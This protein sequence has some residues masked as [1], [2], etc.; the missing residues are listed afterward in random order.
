MKRF[1]LAILALALIGGLVFGLYTIIA[2]LVKDEIGG[3]IDDVISDL[4]PSTSAPDIVPDGMVKI[5]IVTFKQSPESGEYERLEQPMYI[6]KN[7]R[8]THEPTAVEHYRLNTETS[9][10]TIDN[11]ASGNEIHI[12]LDCETCKI[13][14]SIG[15]A[16]LVDGYAIQTIRKGQTP[17]APTLSLPGYTLIGYDHELKPTYEDTVF[18]PS[19]EITNYTLR[20]YLPQG[21]IIDKS[22]YTVNEHFDG[23]FETT[24]TFKDALSLPTPS[25]EG[26]TFRSWN[27]KPDGSGNTVTTLTENTFGDTDLYAIT[28]IKQYTLTFSAVDGL[29]FPSYYLPQGASIS[30]PT[31]PPEAQKPG[32]G[33]TWYTDRALTNVYDFYTMPKENLIL[34]GK[35]QEDTGDGFLDWDPETFYQ[36][37]TI[38]SLIE[39]VD[40]ID[41]IRFYNIQEPIRIEVTYTDKNSL[42][43]EVEKAEKLC[44]YRTSGSLSYSAGIGSFT[45]KDAKCYLSMKVGTSFADSEAKISTNSTG[46]KAYTLLQDKI[47]PRGE[48]YT[49]FYIEKLTETYAVTST[50]Q[51]LY[52][53]EHG[54]K[55][56]PQ[57]G[58]P[59]FEIYEKAK[60]IL[61][62][63]LPNDATAIEKAEYIFNYL[64][65]HIEYDQEA[66][67]IAEKNPA[68]WPKYDAFYLEGVFLYNKAVCDGIAKAYSL[69]C[70]IEGIPCVEVVGPG[71]AWNRVKVDNRWYVVDATFGNLHITGN[72]LSI[73]DHTQFLISDADKAA[74]GYP[75]QN[76]LEFSADKNY[77][78]FDKKEI[79]Y[80]RRTFDFVID[81]VE[82]L[83]RFMEYTLSLKDSFKD[84]TINIIYKINGM[85]FSSAFRAAKQILL[86][87][88]IVFSVTVSCYGSGY[89]TSHKLVYNSK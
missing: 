72:S 66:V 11:A 75:V 14:F 85:D 33:L 20:L 18:L 59:A 21:A 70:N 68:D 67:K 16:D 69:L 1:I 61:N 13:T 81:S 58:S 32:Y 34:Y 12:Y 64:V 45:H 88:G 52:V 24:Y 27:T 44:E 41:F 38:D 79:T 60:E 26:F 7:S 5:M 37:E 77:N 51:L 35:W 19:W 71:H 56:L 9:K 4:L 50:N 31:V 17:K 55:P 65:T 23:C 30:A 15:N 36:T 53:V 46:G 84:C 49:E 6:E 8:Y 43:G 40:F 86:M 73:A 87:R 39:L 3:F 48:S 25:G 29:T 62:A 80:N 2:P 78:Y 82:E 22:G 28:D 57:P 47:M 42:K 74:A 63:I 83:S 89:N 76:Y 10:L 54:Y